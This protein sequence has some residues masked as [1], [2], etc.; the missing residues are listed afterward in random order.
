VEPL[1]VV[2]ET[3]GLPAFPLP[4]GLAR[5]Y[6]GT[7]GFEEPR[8]YAN[9]VQSIDGVT[10]IPSVPGSNR[11]IAAASEAD[12]FVMGLLRACADVVVVGPRTLEASPRGAWTAERAFPAA[13]DEFAELRRRIGRE[14]D[15]EVVVVTR[16][17]V[18][19]TGH[20]AFAAGAVVLT[21]AAGAH[22]ISLPS[23]QIV[24][25]GDGLNGSTTLDVLRGRG[26]T[27]VLSEGG[28]HAWGPLLEERLVDELFLTVSPLL[29]GRTM[30]DSRLGLVEGADLLDDSGPLA[31]RLA[32]VRLGGDH[33]FLRYLF[34]TGSREHPEAEVG[35]EP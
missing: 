4:E 22:R 7:L 6:G 25:V 9:F 35:S 29:T 21:T 20:P 3:P 5:L 34:V 1:E 12:R 32:S 19:D 8:V 10:A 33:L 24:T 27:L 15:P 11:L 28:P 31:A 18:V 30:R 2:F 17:G 23:E 26:H 14:G 16:S 13:A